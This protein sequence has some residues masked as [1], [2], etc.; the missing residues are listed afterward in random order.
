MQITDF[1][2]SEIKLVNQT[3]LERYGH[4]VSIETAESE[5]EPIPG[6]G[7]VMDCPVLYWT[8]RGAHFVV[9]KLAGNR[10][11]AQFFYGEATQFGTGKSGFDNLGDCVITLLQV[12]SDHERQMQGVRSG[13]TGHDLKKL[14]D[15]DGPLVI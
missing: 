8:E 3:L 11:R 10:F 2:D 1:T 5:I 9:F 13:M 6:S 14:D 7:E 4:A 15:Y 12:Q